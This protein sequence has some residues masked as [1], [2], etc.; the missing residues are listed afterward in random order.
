MPAP[1]GNQY[2]LLRTKHGRNK[3]YTDPK[4]LLAACYEYFEDCDSNPWFKKEALKGGDR[5]GEI[6]DIPTSRPYTKKGLCIFIGIDEKTWDSYKLMEDFLPVTTHVESI[7]YTQKFEGAAVGAFN[8][9]IIARDLGL[10]ETTDL[11]TKG[12]SLNDSGV[13]KLTTKEKLELFKL[14]QKMRGDV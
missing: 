10:K 3:K 1:K 7:I 6:I 12:E 9:N 5:A 14:R 13:D 2:Y 8:A 4:G 11:T